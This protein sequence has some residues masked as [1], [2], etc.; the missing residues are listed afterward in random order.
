MSA[1]RDLSDHPDAS[2]GKATKYARIERERRFLLASVPDDRPVRRVLIEDRYLRGTRLRLR[3]STDLGVPDDVI[4]KLTQKIPAADGSPGLITN[5]YL[6][7]AE[8]ETLAEIPADTVRKVRA[9]IP[10]LG[11]DR[12]EG[13][14]AG[15]VLAEAEFDDDAAQAA[16]DPPPGAVAEV[17][18]DV[19]FTGGVLARMTSAGLSELLAGFGIRG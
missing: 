6:S 15:L 3:R 14:L 7:R 10:P 18:T 11:V 5:T 9:S 13:P 16:F 8:Y 1:D 2:P 12:F 4:Y 17:T 19:R